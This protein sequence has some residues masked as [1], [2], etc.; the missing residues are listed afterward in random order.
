MCLS[1][2]FDF[3][4]M[5]LVELIE[6]IWLS[7]KILKPQFSNSN[8]FINI[9][10]KGEPKKKANQKK[11]HSLLAES[12]LTNRSLEDCPINIRTESSKINSYY[13]SSIICILGLFVC[14][15]W[16]S[17]FWFFYAFNLFLI[18]ARV[19]QFKLIYSLFVS[20]L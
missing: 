14:K 4:G 7:N 20:L 3:I 18:C 11:R 6:F 5:G 9:K 13:T 16:L 17:S 1:W 12:Q 10:Q 19:S 15:K 2:G 8:E